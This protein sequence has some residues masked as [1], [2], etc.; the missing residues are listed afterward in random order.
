M[1][2]KKLDQRQPRKPDIRPEKPLENPRMAWGICALLFLAVVAVFGQTIFNG[3][4]NLDDD[5]YVS[6]NAR[7]LHGLTLDGVAWAFTRFHEANWHPLTWLS[8]M[9]DNRIYGEHIGG[10][11][12]TNVL[13]HAAAAVIL[14][15]ALRRMTD[16]LWPSALAAAIFAV[17]PLRTES[18]AW[19]TERKD[20]LSGLFF[21]VVLWTYAEYARRPFSLW[22]YLAVA[23][24]F[25]L[26]LMS[27]PALVTVPCVLLL[28]DC[29]PLRRISGDGNIRRVLLEKVP[30]AAMSAASCTVTFFAQKQGSAVVSL[31][32]LSFSPR[33]ANVLV[34]YASYLGDFFCPTGLTAFYPYPKTG[35]EAWQIAGA[36]FVLAGVTA[37]AILLRRRLP[38]LT[39]GWFWYLGMLVPMI[40]LVQV[41]SQAKA[42]RYTYLPQIGLALA[43][44][45]CVAEAARRRPERARAYGAAA[46]VGAAILM[47]AAFHQT[48]L[49]H[50]NETFWLHALKCTSDNGVANSILGGILN[51]SGKIDRAMYYF[52]EALKC[53]P[54][55][56]RPNLGYGKLLVGLNRQNEALA[57]FTKAAQVDPNNV[58]T[59]CNLGLCLADLNRFDEA[60]KEYQKAFAVNPDDM[61]TLNNYAYLLATCPVDSLRSGKKAV[62]IAL[63]ASD[64]SGGKDPNALDTLAAAYAE[65]GQFDEAVQTARKAIDTAQKNPWTFPVGDMQMRLKLYEERKPF[66]QVLPP[67][68]TTNPSPAKRERGD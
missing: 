64:A 49:W 62:E 40:G 52:R 59:H 21:M 56:P 44:A 43:L 13:L 55:H 51:D 2:K 28:L 35:W 14:F 68:R 19:I 20:V 30:L 65:A 4:F 63:R 3:F 27:K 15:L 32:K 25:A 67:V 33:I 47:G 11:H 26:G 50:D 61:T 16:C 60:C 10:Y 38:C 9:L 5:S 39:V 42:D 34:S 1:G 41:G 12:A 7:I 48:T 37:G 58:E 36:L 66:R 8:L 57:Y 6:H 54:N 17:H 23:V 18:V 46:A 22:R 24:A 53:F 45:W 29:W 31:D